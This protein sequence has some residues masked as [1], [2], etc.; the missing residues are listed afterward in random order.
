MPTT[1]TILLDG[2]N[3]PAL[4]SREIPFM[5]RKL[6]II[7]QDFRLLPDRTVYDNIAFAMQVIESPHR[8][9]KRRVMNVLDLV[10]LRRRAYAH[11]NELS[12]GEQQR[13][14][15]ARA[16]VNRP[17]VVIADEPTGNL[18]PETSRDIMGIFQEIND[19]GTTII[20]ATHDKEIV[21]SMSKRVIAIDH[22]E[23]VRDELNG[24]YGYEP[25]Q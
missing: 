18:D 24:V 25:E 8:L 14:A 22:G 23:I 16:I 9:I 17:K 12:G 13:I 3:I 2:Q 19:D 4:T 6:G 5:R 15:I 7:F 20:M 1:G 10:G 21:D 11:P